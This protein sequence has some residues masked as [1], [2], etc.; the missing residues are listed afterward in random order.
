[1]PDDHVVRLYEG[2]ALVRP[3]S[4]VAQQA[5]NAGNVLR[6]VRQRQSRQTGESF[7][8]PGDDVVFAQFLDHALLILGCDEQLAGSI[9]EFTPALGVEADVL[10]LGDELQESSL[11]KLRAFW[12]FRHHGLTKA[13]L[14]GTPTELDQAT[15]ADKVLP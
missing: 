2:D 9:K 4:L 5:N 12:R 8:W 13:A 1:M 7:A 3:V 11:V 10:V 14:T 6:V 15:T